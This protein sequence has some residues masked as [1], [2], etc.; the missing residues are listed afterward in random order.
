MLFPPHHSKVR[1][2]LNRTADHS[3]NLQ[4]PQATFQGATN[5]QFRNILLTGGSYAL[6]MLRWYRP[7]MSSAHCIKA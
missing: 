1:Q 3:I 4:F 7:P 6:A 5:I 2:G